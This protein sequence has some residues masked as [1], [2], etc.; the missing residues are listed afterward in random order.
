[1]RARWIELGQV[2]AIDLYASCQGLAEAMPADADPVVL[3]GRPRRAHISI[4]ASQS[5]AVELDL[6]ACRAL[7]IEVVRRPLGG[8][9]VL[10]D[11]EQ[12][13]FFFLMPARA[14][15]ASRAEFFSA[16]L[17]PAIATYRAFGLAVERVGTGD[18]WL[19]G[20]KIL[21]SGA[22]TIGRAHALGASFLL[23]F[24]AAHFARLVRCPSAAFRAWLAEEL[25]LGMTDWQTHAPPPA[26]GLLREVFRR[27]LA[28][29]LGWR[30]HDD[31]P[32]A[33]ER[34]AITAAREE[35]GEPAERPGRRLVECGIKVNHHR[36]LL[37]RA[38]AQ[39]AVRLVIRRGRIG[40]LAA[41][42]LKPGAAEACIDAPPDER[43][44]NRALLAQ[45]DG[46]ASRHW[47]ARIA[48]A[49]QGWRRVHGA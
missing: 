30:L 36:Y 45:L 40:R 6:A 28:R 5:P 42:G 24:D 31:E 34:E 32:T 18:A 29:A 13:C 1:M 11:A 41:E 38:D 43:P 12:W 49:A 16:C 21:G 33:P 46:S 8:G 25:D 27:E 22:A 7:G 26:P 10:V 39:G 9:S 3:W 2:A 19:H 35:L 48:L 44:L 47:A 4:G 37:E 20:R 23:R 17:A 14:A 15:P